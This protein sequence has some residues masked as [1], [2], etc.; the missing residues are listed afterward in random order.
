MSVVVKVGK[1]LGDHLSQEPLWPWVPGEGLGHTSRCC[2]SQV[3]NSGSLAHQWVFMA[4]ARTLDVCFLGVCRFSCGRWEMLVLCAVVSV[5]TFI[6]TSL[7]PRTESSPFL[8]SYLPKEEQQ[9]ERVPPSGSSAPAVC[10]PASPVP[11]TPVCSCW[12]MA[13]ETLKQSFSAC[14]PPGVTY[15][16]S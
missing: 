13:V 7:V 3:K 16:R 14:F 2:W 12:R 1:C 5:G 10:N 4:V 15:W 6:R 11:C 9:R 8:G